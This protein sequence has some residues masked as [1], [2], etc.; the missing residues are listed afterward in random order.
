M[1]IFFPHLIFLEELKAQDKTIT[2]YIEAI[3]LDLKN[4]V[5][6]FKCFDIKMQSTV[7]D[8]WFQDIFLV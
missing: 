8:T 5:F 1:N 2:G 7:D 3:K 4:S 6:L